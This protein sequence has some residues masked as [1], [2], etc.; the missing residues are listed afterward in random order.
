M[1]TL[2]LHC[3]HCGS[4]ARGAR[5]ACPRRQA[6]LLLVR[7]LASQPRE[8]DP[9]CLSGSSS[10]GA[11]AFLVRTRASCSASHTGCA[12][13]GTPSQVGS[14]KGAQLP[15]FHSTLVASDPEDPTPTILGLD[16]R[17][18]RLC[19][20][21]RTT[22]GCGSL[23]AARHDK[24]WRMSLGIGAGK[25]CQRLR[26]VIPH[27]YRPGH[28]STSFLRVYDSVIPQERHTA[29]GKETGETAHVER[30][31]NTLRKPLARFVHM[32]LGKVSF[33]W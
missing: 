11:P 21:K 28:G 25:A 27:E 3:P 17:M 31:K 12:S 5:W 9:Q 19:S 14:K 15:P 26:E 22:P 23:C 20:K 33:I 29:V 16:E 2:T 10:R 24:W 30:W 8:S 1:V 32:S 6:E 4:E 13:L 7:L 18:A